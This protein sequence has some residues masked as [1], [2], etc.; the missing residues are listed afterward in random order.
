MNPPQAPTTERRGADVLPVRIEDEE[1]LIGDFLASLV[2]SQRDRP[3]T[4]NLKVAPW[5]LDPALVPAE[6]VTFDDLPEEITIHLAVTNV[7]Q[8][9]SLIEDD[10]P[11]AEKLRAGDWYKWPEF[12]V[13][14]WL[15][16]PPGRAAT[17]T[18]W[19]RVAL[20][21]TDDRRLIEAA[22]Y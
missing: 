15:V 8:V 2:Y 9:W 12:E 14:G 20:K 16:D 5:F 6:S 1:F 21:T 3:R 13:D 7:R 22:I 17:D 11:D 4:V 10:N 18:L 19:V